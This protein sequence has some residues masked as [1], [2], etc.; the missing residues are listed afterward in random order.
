[1]CFRYCHNNYGLSLLQ[2]DLLW[3][4]I[5][6][7]VRYVSFYIPYGKTGIWSVVFSCFQFVTHC[8]LV[9]H[10]WNHT[11]VSEYLQ[12]HITAHKPATVTLNCKRV[13]QYDDPVCCRIHKKLWLRIQCYCLYGTSILGILKP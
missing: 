11:N 8:T 9:R 6:L 12:T 7:N 2:Y 10:F 4:E 1:M 13:L 3:E 5:M